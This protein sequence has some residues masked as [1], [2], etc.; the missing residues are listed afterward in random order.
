MLAVYGS[1]YYQGEVAETVEVIMR[2][3][4][5]KRFL[6][7]LNFQAEQ[8]HSYLRAMCGG[9]ASRFRINPVYFRGTTMEKRIKMPARGRI[10]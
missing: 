1:S 8:V 4:A 10:R 9:Y 6:F 7:V 2:E 3:K 5:D